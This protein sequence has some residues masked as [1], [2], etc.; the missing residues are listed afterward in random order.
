MRIDDPEDTAA[1]LQEFAAEHRKAEEILTEAIRR[2]APEVRAQIQANELLH[3]EYSERS[4]AADAL[5]VI[6][7]AQSRRAA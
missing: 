4:A 6:I 7:C 2:A 5:A 3:T 1:R